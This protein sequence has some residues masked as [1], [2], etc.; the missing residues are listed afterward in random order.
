MKRQ[1]IRSLLLVMALCLTATSADAQ[2]DRNYVKS[3]IKKWGT[4]K[5]VAITKTN[6]DVALYGTCGYA[7]SNVPASLLSKLK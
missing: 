4:C 5:N 1:M 6:G 3:Q 2:R 7:A